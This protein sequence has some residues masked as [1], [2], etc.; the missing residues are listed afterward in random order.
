VFASRYGDLRR[1]LAAIELMVADEPVSPTSFA[2]SVHN[3]IAAVSSIAR[4]HMEDTTCIAAG[5]ASAAAGFIEA[6]ALL[7]GGAERALLVCYDEPLP[8]PYDVYADEPPALWAW[9]WLLERAQA[10]EPAIGLRWRTI[11][12]DE[13]ATTGPA[14]PAGLQVL[15]F[16]VTGQPVLRQMQDTRCWEWWRDG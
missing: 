14:L 16:F 6:A 9:A 1:S 2:T 11:A 15:Q 3:A 4:G 10:G 7:G 5:T 12:G 13:H 8:A